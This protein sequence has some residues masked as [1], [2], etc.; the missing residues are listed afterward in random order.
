MSKLAELNVLFGK[1]LAELLGVQKE[2]ESL[3]YSNSKST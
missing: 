1:Q 3:I 2:F